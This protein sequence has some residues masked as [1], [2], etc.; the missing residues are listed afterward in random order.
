MS[1]KNKYP[2][3]KSEKVWQE[4][5]SPEEF[6]ILRKKGT[7]YAFSVNLM[8]TMRKEPTCVKDVESHSMRAIVNL[9]VIVVGPVMTNPLK[10]LWN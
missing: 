8:T 9:T 4:E 1:K 3:E 6:N 2:I 10:E 5:L 7:E